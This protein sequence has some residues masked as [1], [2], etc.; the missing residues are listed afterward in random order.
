MGD[1]VDTYLTLLTSHDATASMTIALSMV[2]LFCQNQI[3]RCLREASNKVKIRHSAIGQ[4]TVR[5]AIADQYKV[6]IDEGKRNSKAVMDMVQYNLYAMNAYFK[7]LQEIKISDEDIF[8]TMMALRGHKLGEKIPQT[9]ATRLIN[10]TGEI[11]A[12]YG[13]PDV[14]VVRG[15]ALGAYYAYSDFIDHVANAKQDATTKFEDSLS[16]KGKLA[17]FADT[18]VNVVNA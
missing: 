12:C 3:N 17:K 8:K 18:L 1:D 15:T 13:M 9:G 16:E 2:R 14:D 10:E 7:Q 4:A 6:A 11:M 5:G